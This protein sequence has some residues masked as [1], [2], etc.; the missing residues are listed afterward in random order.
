M[1]VFAGKDGLVKVDIASSP[2]AIGEVENWSLEDSSE[3]LSR[4][5]LGSTGT[6]KKAT[7]T[8]ATGSLELYFDNADSG[9]GELKAGATID[10]TLYPN[11]E[12]SGEP[13]WTGT[14]I[15]SSVSHNGGVDGWNRK[16]VSFEVD[17][18]MDYDGT[19]AA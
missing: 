6:K 14:A 12:E 1:S 15:V 13:E 18:E 7:H 10:L 11:G 17:G 5:V 4:R 3:I 9:Q 2:T 19:V 8:N 16:S